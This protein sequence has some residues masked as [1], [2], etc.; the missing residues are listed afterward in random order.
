MPKRKKLF[1]KEEAECIYIEGYD[2]TTPVHGTP[3]QKLEAMKYLIECANDWIKDC[4]HKIAEIKAL[5]AQEHNKT[6]DKDI[7][8]D[9][10][11]QIEIAR[12]DKATLRRRL[13]K[14]RTKT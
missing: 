12:K 9:F 6:I 11:E 1:G 4:K 10:Q 2:L 13:E 14:L 3:R 5:H 8:I 7:V